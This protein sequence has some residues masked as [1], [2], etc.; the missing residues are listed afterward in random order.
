MDQPS[1]TYPPRIIYC[2]NDLDDSR[3][4]QPLA[5]IVRQLLRYLFAQGSLT[6]LLRQ[7]TQN[8]R[9]NL[10]DF[11]IDQ[12][13]A[14]A[15]RDVAIVANGQLAWYA[16]TLF[17]LKLGNRWDLSHSGSLGDLIFS[18]KDIR[19]L[20]FRICKQQRLPF[21]SSIPRAWY[22]VRV[23]TWEHQAWGLHFEILEFF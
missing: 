16:R 17:R 21:A 15:Y 7:E 1:R 12:S 11:F 10:L 8:I 13:Q 19:R 22:W 20:S 2:L 3:R 9:V 6:Q 18:S 23:S 14:Y 5:F 4:G